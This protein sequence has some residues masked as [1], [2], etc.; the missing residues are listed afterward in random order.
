MEAGDVERRRRI[1]RKG[2]SVVKVKKN[3][4]IYEGIVRR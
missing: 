4:R 1:G 3:E 2:F